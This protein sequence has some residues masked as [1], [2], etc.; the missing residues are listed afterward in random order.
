MAM[1]LRLPLRTSLLCVCLF[2]PI[3]VFAQSTVPG[4]TGSGTATFNSATAYNGVALSALDFGTGL[5]VPGDTSASGNFH[6]TLQGTDRSIEVDCRVS[7]GS[8]AANNT[9]TFSG[10]CTVDMG[11]GSAPS[12]GVTFTVVAVPDGGNKGTL[13]LTLGPSKLAAAAIQDGILTIR[14]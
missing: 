13:T 10:T 6:I 14:P 3:S 4:V 5:E 2:G 7:A 9:A 1:E 12:T 11:D 8:I